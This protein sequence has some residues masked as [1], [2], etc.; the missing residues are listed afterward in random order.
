MLDLL[1]VI[2]FFITEITFEWAEENLVM[3]AILIKLH[4]MAKAVGTIKHIINKRFLA[5]AVKL[6]I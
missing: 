5:R 2:D 1:L 3:F 6:S 4:L